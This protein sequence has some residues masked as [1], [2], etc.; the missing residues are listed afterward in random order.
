M[1]TVGEQVPLLVEGQRLTRDAFRGKAFK[2][3]PVPADRIWRSRVFPGLWLNG[4][5]F[6]AG[7]MPKVLATLQE[8]VQ[9]SE[10]AACAAKLSARLQS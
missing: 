6:L 1:A 4:P 2:L 7:D 3:M 9:S 8:G 5:A 10:H